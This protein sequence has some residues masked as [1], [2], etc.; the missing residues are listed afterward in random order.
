MY[1]ITFKGFGC[2]LAPEEQPV[3]GVYQ[4][5]DGAVIL[6]TGS[7]EIPNGIAFSNDNKFLY[8]AN[9]AVMALFTVSMWWA[10]NL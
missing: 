1:G 9:S 6:K 5:K 3:R 4:I 10:M 2:E 8:V 7:I